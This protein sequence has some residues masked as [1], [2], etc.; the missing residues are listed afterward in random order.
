MTE[1][2]KIETLYERDPKT[3]RVN[4]S[5]LRDEV[6]GLIKEWD[7][8]EKIDGTNIRCIWKDSKLTFGGRTQNAQIPADLIQWLLEH[9]KAEDIHNIFA[10]K[11]VVIY[12]EGYGGKIQ[13]GQAYSP[14]SKFI[15][16]DI[17]VNYSWLNWENTKGVAEKMGLEV[18][19]FLGTM[20]LEYAT[21][22]VREGFK[23]QLG[24]GSKDAEGL[25]GRTREPLFDKK[26]NRLIVKL[27]TKDFLGKDY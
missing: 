18:V 7:W 5:V 14:E 12:G 27:K 8:T 11:E 16:F 2:H 25:I 20:P 24:D 17:L 4:P 1:Y 26:G 3:F 19:P 6:Y 13:Q 15:V 23:S 9:V 10:D 22:L 21:R